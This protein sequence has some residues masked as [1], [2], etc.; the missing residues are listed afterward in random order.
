MIRQELETVGISYSAADI[1]RLL[2]SGWNVSYSAQKMTA[3]RTV[4]KQDVE[5]CCENSDQNSDDAGNNLD[6]QEKQR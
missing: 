6:S 1:F 4:Q 2:E 5:D 3:W